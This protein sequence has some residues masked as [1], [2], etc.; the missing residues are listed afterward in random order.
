MAGRGGRARQGGQLSSIDHTATA[1]Q[2]HR[3]VVTKFQSTPFYFLLLPLHWPLP[4]VP[5][6]LLS[7]HLQTWPPT[8][9]PTHPLPPFLPLPLPFCNHGV[10]SSFFCL[11]CYFFIFFSQLQKN[12]NS[13]SYPGFFGF[14]SF[15]LF[16]FFKEFFFI[17]LS[18]RFFH[19]FSYFFFIRFYSIQRFLFFF[20]VIFFLNYTYVPF[21]L[22]LFF[23]PSL[24]FPYH[25]RLHNFFFPPSL[26]PFFH[27]LFCYTR[28]S[29]VNSTK[30]SFFPFFETYIKKFWFQ[31]DFFF[32]S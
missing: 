7:A 31:D 18:S 2:S 1:P 5:L 6:P 3:N 24:R 30:F 20:P 10:L 15:F 4:A 8:H 26:S 13:V 14:I 22:S 9:P 11:S 23:S 12:Y 19:F 21:F 32:L 16:S 25:F 17:F 27:L 28:P 29:F